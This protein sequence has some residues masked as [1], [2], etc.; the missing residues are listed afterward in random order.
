MVYEFIQSLIDVKIFGFYKLSDAGSLNGLFLDDLFEHVLL[1][2]ELV[3]G[4]IFEHEFFEG[5]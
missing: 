5:G 3:L 2:E 4:E 1:T